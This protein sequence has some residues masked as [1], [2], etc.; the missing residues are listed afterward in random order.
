[1]SEEFNTDWLSD[2]DPIVMYIPQIDL[3]LTQGR[4][5]VEV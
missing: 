5:T 3:Y 2:G 4:E 1:M